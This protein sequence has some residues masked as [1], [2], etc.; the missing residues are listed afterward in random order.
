MRVTRVCKRGSWEGVQ[1]VM[2]FLV[3]D[4]GEEKAFPQTNFEFSLK[5]LAKAKR[6]R[7]R[8]QR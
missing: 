4:V 8:V 3:E 5:A 6:Q 7:S 2:M 1:V